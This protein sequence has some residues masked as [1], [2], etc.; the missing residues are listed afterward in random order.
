MKIILLENIKG[1]G[2]KFDVKEVKD[3]YAKNF[4]F[5]RGLAKIAAA[6]SIK[7]LETKKAAY[8]KEERE[9]KNKM[10]VL[11]KDLAGRE[12]SFT[13]KTGKKREIFGS[14]NKGDIKDKLLEINALFTNAEVNLERPI[15]T[16]GEHRVDID[17]SRGVKAKI[18]LQVLA[19]S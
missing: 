2:R 9:I 3:G 5:P 1:V 11:A 17:L 15:K 7:E 4:L 14:I 18:K 19:Q 10:E 16:L 8:E 6:Q 12:F 13:V